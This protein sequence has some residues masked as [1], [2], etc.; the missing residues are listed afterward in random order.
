[1]ERAY[2]VVLVAGRRSSAVPPGLQPLEPG[3]ADGLAP[4]KVRQDAERVETSPYGDA[5]ASGYI[6]PGS[7]SSDRSAKGPSCSAR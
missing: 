2:V 7:T 3:R 4:G 1:M 5:E 6:T